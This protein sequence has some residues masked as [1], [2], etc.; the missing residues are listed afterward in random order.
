MLRV[1]QPAAPTYEQSVSAEEQRGFRAL[2]GD[3]RHYVADMLCSV[4]RSVHRA[5]ANVADLHR[6][7]VLHLNVGTSIVSFKKLATSDDLD[8]I[9]PILLPP[10]VPALMI[11]MMMS[12]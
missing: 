5:Y 6:L 8:T 9:A 1:K 10:L 2:W 3:M 12:G 7:Q 4:P 11:P